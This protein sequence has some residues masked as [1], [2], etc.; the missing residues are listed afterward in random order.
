MVKFQLLS[1]IKCFTQDSPSIRRK[2]SVI[3]KTLGTNNYKWLM[4]WPIATWPVISF[5]V[6]NE[7]CYADVMEISRI[8]IVVWNLHTTFWQNKGKL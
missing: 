7:K 5:S 8:W 2:F 6:I 1:K 3:C 4:L